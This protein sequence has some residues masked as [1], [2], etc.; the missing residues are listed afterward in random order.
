MRNSQRD[1]IGYCLV[2]LEYLRRNLQK[3]ETLERKLYIVNQVEKEIISALYQPI[4][5]G[6]HELKYPYL[7]IPDKIEGKIRFA[8]SILVT[9]TAAATKRTKLCEILC[10]IKF[11]LRLEEANKNGGILEE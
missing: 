8:E 5:E 3:E 10:Q 11:E 9:G 2:Q 7:P 1:V 4:I 6:K